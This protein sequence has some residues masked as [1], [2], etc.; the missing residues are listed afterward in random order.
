MPSCADPRT[1]LPGDTHVN[2]LRLEEAQLGVALA[3]TD[4]ARQ[5]RPEQILERGAEAGHGI[6]MVTPYHAWPP[7]P[8]PPPGELR[9]A[10]HG[11]PQ[12]G[13]GHPYVPCRARSTTDVLC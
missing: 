3:P 13:H 8:Q 10:C 2:G 11:V 4:S 7:G 12:H 9:G 1:D 6:L 5:R